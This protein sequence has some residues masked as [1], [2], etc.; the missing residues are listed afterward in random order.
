MAPKRPTFSPPKPV[1]VHL[2]R[3]K[4]LEIGRL[5][6]VVRVARCNPKGSYEREATRHISVEGL[7]GTDSLLGLEEM[8]RGALPRA[9]GK[10]AALPTPK[11]SP[12]KTSGY[13]SISQT[14]R[15]LIFV[16]LGF[17]M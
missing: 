1:N 11:P 13:G 15:V 10:S 3:E 16:S 9:L 4:D 6:W 2:P 17:L 14:L 12:N 5:P 7:R 8:R